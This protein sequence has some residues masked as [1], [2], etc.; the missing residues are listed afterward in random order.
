MTFKQ[1]EGYK[2]MNNVDIREKNGPSKESSSGKA[3]RSML[4]M[5]SE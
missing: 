5:L 2:E 3:Q 4:G 1:I